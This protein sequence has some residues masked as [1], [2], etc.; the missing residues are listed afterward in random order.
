MEAFVPRPRLT[1]GPTPEALLA[2]NPVDRY[3]TISRYAR[4]WS[5]LPKWMAD[6]RLAALPDAL[7]HPG[8][9]ATALANL[10]EHS[11]SQVSKLFSRHR[12]V[13]GQEA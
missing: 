13:V 1:D 12:T 5:T 4:D 9:T 7:A 3:V 2:L 6:M 8:M 11:L 10:A